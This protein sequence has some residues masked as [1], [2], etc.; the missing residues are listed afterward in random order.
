MAYDETKSRWV[1]QVRQ[2]GSVDKPK[3]VLQLIYGEFG[4]GKTFYCA[5]APGVVVVDIDRGENIKSRTEKLNY[6]Y[7][8]PEGL[9]ENLKRLF[10]DIRD[11]KDIFEPGAPLGY[12]KSLALDSWTK[13]NESLLVEIVGEDTLENSK[14]G[15]DAYMALK[16]RQIFLVKI[17]KEIAFEQDINVIVTALPMI[18]GDEAERMKRDDA[19]ASA[20]SGFSV[21]HGMPNLVGAF[22][23]QIGAEFDEV[24]YFESFPSG[25]HHNRL[26]TNPHGDYQAKSRYGISESII[27]ATFAKVQE[28]AEKV[29]NLT[30]ATTKP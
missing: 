6:F 3:G 30:K 14:P 18:E 25:G 4:V 22:K 29:K 17:L 1:K 26:W 23:K 13:I 21:V 5:S 8:R 19:K 11:R 16:N 7:F 27:D 28:A 24:Y 12:I 9:Y 20:K 15:W 2:Y 10:M